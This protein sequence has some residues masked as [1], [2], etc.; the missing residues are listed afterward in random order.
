MTV[1]L[2]IGPYCSNSLFWVQTCWMDFAFMMCWIT[3]PNH[4][5]PRG[6]GILLNARTFFGSWVCEPFH[7]LQNSM[8]NQAATKRT[9]AMHATANASSILSIGYVC[10]RWVERDDDRIVSHNAFSRRITRYRSHGRFHREITRGLF[11][12][13]SS[14]KSKKIALFRYFT[15]F[16]GFAMVKSDFSI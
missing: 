4:G 15:W 13:S 7:K 11:S 1:S 8:N 6:P 14:S 3:E 2:N 16:L 12:H 9:T 5:N 10:C